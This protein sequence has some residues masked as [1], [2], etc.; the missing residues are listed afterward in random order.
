MK[1]E[2]TNLLQNVK[3]KISYSTDN[4]TTKQ[5]VFTFAGTIANFINDDWEI[6]ERLIDFYHI[7]D[8]EH[9]GEHA[10]AAFV[11]SAAGRGGLDKMSPCPI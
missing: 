5:M 8:K 7:E 2:H 11:K 4:W 3:S 6:V 10:A 9:E 1:L